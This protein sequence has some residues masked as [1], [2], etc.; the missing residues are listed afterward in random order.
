MSCD[1]SVV[2]LWHAA[3]NTGRLLVSAGDCRRRIGD[4]Q[5][6]YAALHYPGWYKGT[7]HDNLICTWNMG[8]DACAGDSGGPLITRSTGDTFHKVHLQ[9]FP[10]T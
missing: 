1:W 9:S 7:Y 8:K 3:G 4:A 6:K 5:K 10:H 2:Q